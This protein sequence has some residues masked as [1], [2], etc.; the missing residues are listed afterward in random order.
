MF[1][2]PEKELVKLPFPAVVDNTMLETWDECQ[3]EY[4]FEFGLDLALTETSTDLHAGASFAT[5]LEHFRRAYYGEGLDFLPAYVRGAHALWDAYGDFIPA[6][7]NPKSKLAMMTGYDYFLTEAFPP[8]TDHSQPF[9]TGG[10]PA[11]EFSFALPIPEVLHPLTGEPVLYCGRL[12]QIVEHGGALFVEDDKTTKALGQRWRS[13]W[14]MR[15]QFTGYVWGV[16]Q[17]GYPVVGALI[18]GISILKYDHG[19]EEVIVYRGAH[20]IRQWYDEV[21]QRLNE[22]KLAYV[23][24]AFHQSLGPSCSMYSGCPFQSL[25]QADNPFLWMANYAKRAWNP[26]HRDQVNDL[27]QGSNPQETQRVIEP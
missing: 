17:F 18:R 25:C 7:A 23:T 14:T 27:V 6:D 15:S 1:Y 20:D 2:M 12:D 3:T 11:I 8:G 21:V 26:L 16:Q 24:G 4:A 19:H 13:N 5:G 22:I 10:K 9:V